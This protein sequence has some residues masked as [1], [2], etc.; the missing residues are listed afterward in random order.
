MTGSLSEE[1]KE[2]WIYVLGGYSTR[3]SAAASS[4]IDFT[5]L[6]GPRII[7]TGASLD[8]PRFDYRTTSIDSSEL[9]SAGNNQVNPFL[10]T[11]LFGDKKISGAY[12]I[13]RCRWRVNTNLATYQATFWGFLIRYQSFFRGVAP[14]LA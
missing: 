4:T 10:G 8:F 1:R 13:F 2:D 7:T 6:S 14:A 5:F 9:G 12:D 11:P 3:S